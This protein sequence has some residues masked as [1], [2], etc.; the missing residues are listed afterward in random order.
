ME[1]LDNV[2]AF[3]PV[4]TTTNRWFRVNM[5]EEEYMVSFPTPA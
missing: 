5:G 1:I 3:C 4:C 2:H